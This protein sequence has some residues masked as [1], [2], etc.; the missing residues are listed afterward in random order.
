MADRPNVI[1]ITTD[2]QRLDSLSCMGSSFIRTPH[3]DRLARE[4]VLFSRAYCTNPVCTPS[5]ASIFSGLRVSRHG[6][7]NVGTKIANDVPLLSHRLAELGYRTHS[8]GKMHFQPFGSLES[9]ESI[10]RWGSGESLTSGPY[11]GF[12]TVELACGHTTYGMTGAYGE[13]ILDQIDGNRAVLEEFRRSHN[14]T[15]PEFGGGAQETDLPARFQNSVWTAERAC[16][17][18]R[19]HDRSGVGKDGEEQ[20][21]FL[22][23]GFEDPHH[24][25][26]VPIDYENRVLA[27]D[28]PLPDFTPGELDDKPPHFIANR[29]GTLEASDARGEYPVAGACSRYGSGYDIVSDD[30]ARLGRAHY[31]TLVQLIDEQVGR[32]LDCLDDLSLAA[33]T[34]VVFT[35]DHGE[36]LG[37]HGLWCK[38]PF[39]YEELVNIPLIIRGPSWFA[40]PHTTDAL[41]S[42]VDLVPTIL[43]AIGA[44]PGRFE[45]ELLD[46]V[47]LGPVLRGELSTV[48]DQVLIECIDDPGK[49]RLKTIVTATGKCTWYAGS[50]F[51]EL[52]DLVKDPAEKVNQWDGRGADR[53]HH[54]SML[55]DELER[56]ERR[57][58]RWCYA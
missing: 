12:E 33:N 25:H 14:L 28:V 19:D 10:E 51:G 50:E 30:A 49:L 44:V 45:G 18:I 20:P 4:G 17:F 29:D 3:L 6:A 57:E 11:Y 35:T 27:A 23:V 26:A 1:V 38:G 58:R 55:L 5:R 15:E 56:N 53:A 8:V 13:W 39:H 21:F 40:R 24:P 32:I 54:L 41:V 48:R 31:Y 16:A 47:D 42:H 46:G 43:S 22:A 2:Q 37:D 34:I 52:Y 7:W 36:L 9:E